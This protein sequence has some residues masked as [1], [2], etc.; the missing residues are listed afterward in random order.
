MASETFS[1]RF[2]ELGRPDP[3]EI[4]EFLFLFRATYAAA[5][6]LGVHTSVPLTTKGVRAFATRL[7]DM[8]INN[9]PNLLP[10]SPY[11]GA[12]MG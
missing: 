12:R 5:T 11:F 10:D 4:A 1:L 6:Q 7:R 9:C 3:T 2:N 8:E